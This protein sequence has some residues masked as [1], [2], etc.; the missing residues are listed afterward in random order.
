MFSCFN[1]ELSAV[2]TTLSDQKDKEDKSE[3]PSPPPPFL[4][5]PNSLSRA[6]LNV[7]VHCDVCALIPRSEGVMSSLGR[8]PSVGLYPRTLSS[9]PTPPPKVLPD[10]PVLVATGKGIQ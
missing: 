6:W 3:D 9:A 2:G 4:Y 1:S 10:T 8:G 5:P 7:A